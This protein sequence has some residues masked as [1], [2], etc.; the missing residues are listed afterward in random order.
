MLKVRTADTLGK[1]SL[2]RAAE[3]KKGAAK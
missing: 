3:A 2:D 1:T